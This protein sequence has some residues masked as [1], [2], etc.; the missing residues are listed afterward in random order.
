MAH[1]QVI[2]GLKTQIAPGDDAYHFAAV[3]HWKARNPELL[4]QSQHLAHGVRRRND[5]RVAQHARFV[6]LDLGDLGGLL[7]RGQ[8]FVHNAHAPLL[9]DGNGQTGFGDRVHRG[10]DQRQIQ[11][12]VAGKTGGE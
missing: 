3:A 11:C 1:G 9:R 7:L 12:N 2:A 10:R 6:A 8:V 4:R 5:H